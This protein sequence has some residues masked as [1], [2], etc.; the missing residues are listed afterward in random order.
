ME[1]RPL[2]TSGSSA[3]KQ[4]L[5]E[6][7]LDGIAGGS[8]AC[9]DPQLAVDRA[10]MGVHG[11]QANDEALRDLHACQSRRYQS[12]HLYFPCRQPIRVGRRRFLCR[13]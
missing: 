8:T 12:Q 6:V 4:S 7:M 5:Q 10:H 9:A 3:Q 2:W 11:E 1:G 13:R